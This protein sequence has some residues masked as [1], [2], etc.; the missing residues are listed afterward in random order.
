MNIIAKSPF[1]TI[2]KAEFFKMPSQ[3]PGVPKLGDVLAMKGLFDG[4]LHSKKADG[5]LKRLQ[6]MRKRLLESRFIMTQ[7][8]TTCTRWVS[9]TRNLARNWS[10]K[11]PL[12]KKNMLRTW[13]NW[14]QN[15]LSVV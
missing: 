13:K 5:P 12:I 1:E 10:K 8:D 9:F 4:D 7:P 6:H 14:N 15:T 3:E 2:S 11:I